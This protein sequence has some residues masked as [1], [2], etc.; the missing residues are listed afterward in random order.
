MTV[1]TITETKAGPLPRALAA[2]KGVRRSASGWIALCPAHEDRTPSLSVTTGADGRVLVKCH[3]GCAFGDVVRAMGLEP[4]DLF[5]APLARPQLVNAADPSRRDVRYFDYVDAGGALLYRVKRE[6][7]GNGDKRCRPERPNGSGGFVPGRG[8]VPAL[9][10]RLPEL[11]EAVALERRVFVVEGEP[12][13]EQLEAW[14]LVATTSG[15][16][17]SWRPE[18]AAHFAG[19]H[20]VILPDNDEP[21]RKYAD[22]VRESLTGV[23]SSVRVVEIPNLPPKGDVVDFARAGGTRAALEAIVEAAPPADV[24]RRPFLDDAEIEQLPPRR[25]LVGGLVPDAGLT[26][27]HGP[28]GVGKSFAAIAL[29][30]DVASGRGFV[31]RPVLQPGPVVYVAAE[32]TAGLGMR[33][34]AWKEEYGITRT[35]GVQFRTDPVQLLEPR[36]VAAFLADVATLPAPPRLIVFDTL[37]RCMVGGEE[38]SAKD[39]GLAMDA[40]DRIRRATGAAVLLVHHS[41]KDGDTERGST[42]LRGAV[43]AMLSLKNDDGRLRLVCEKMKDAPEFA[44]IAL[45]LKRV[46]D[47]CVVITATGP[48]QYGAA[49]LT[50]SECQALETLQ[51]PMFEDGASASRWLEA[52]GL[53]QRTFFKAAKELVLRRLV[54]KSGP[55]TRPL[56]TVSPTGSRRLTATTATT[57]VGLQCS[58]GQSLPAPLPLLERGSDGSEARWHSHDRPPEAA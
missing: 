48:L 9:L 22:A 21:G 25:F 35:L 16:A 53:P 40:A 33:L 52:S 5:P 44:P 30:C 49:E 28:P 1:A 26:E 37:A 58:G 46:G 6:D 17:T 23:A 55:P 20:V 24:P 43:D 47:S 36:A 31:G 32:G 34:R 56:Y 42:A 27:L 38:N 19:A 51:S 18:F 39:M 15:S 3:A 4:G 14:G 8:D 13:V 12:K 54:D 10:Y 57:A 2:L 29:A 11:I 45:E 41:R 50:P 7:F